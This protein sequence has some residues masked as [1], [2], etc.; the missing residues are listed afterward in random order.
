MAAA[1]AVLDPRLEGPAS[2]LGRQHD[3]KKETMPAYSMGTGSRAAATNKVFLS[4]AHIARANPGVSPGPH[5]DPNELFGDAP[6]FGF[7]TD[8]Q[9]KPMAVAKYPDSSVDMTCATVDSQPFKYKSTKSVNFGTEA[10]GTYKNAETI[11]VHPGLALGMNSPCA[12]EY[13]AE[14]AE[15]K[16]AKSNPRYSFGPKPSGD[17]KDKA[18]DKGPVKVVPRMKLNPTATP[19]HVGPGSH[20]QPASLGNQPNSARSSAPSYSFGGSPRL[21]ES[22][23]TGP[24]VDA[25]PRL[26]SL[27]RQVVSNHKT[28]GTC[29]FGEA[30]RDGVARSQLVMTTADRGP[31]AMLPKPN[32]HFDLPKMPVGRLPAKPGM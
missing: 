7:G 17:K 14:K 8:E 19:R 3:S 28:S 27:G 16:V 6:M 21:P 4:K 10:K 26:S 20:N 31:A 15:P 25:S 1:M 12:L 2:A 13:Y 24:I 29:T 23:S 9:R 22:R 5:Y 32:H 30:T 11:R 18:A